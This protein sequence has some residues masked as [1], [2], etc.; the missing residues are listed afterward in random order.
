MDHR[1]LLDRPVTRSEVFASLRVMESEIA[2]VRAR[3]V[4]ELRRLMRGWGAEPSPSELAAEMDVSVNTAKRLLEAAWRTP[5]RSEAMSKFSSGGWSFDRAAAMAALVGVGADDDTLAEAEGRDIAGVERLRGLQK[6][7]TK[8][9]EHEAHAQRRL[10]TWAS[11]DESV[12]FVHAELT[13][14]DW[15]TVTTALDKRADLFPSK[16][17]TADQRRADALVAI[18]QDWLDGVASGPGRSSG[19]VV[20]VVVAADT[21]AQTNAEAG[22]SVTA[23]PRVGPE[24]LERIMCEGSVE[25]VVEPGTGVPLAVGP[26]SRVIPPKVRRAVLARDGG[27]VIAGCTSSYRLQVHHVTPRSRGGTHDMEN[28]VTLCWYHHHVSI[29]GQGWSIDPDSPARNRRLIPP[30]SGSPPN[31]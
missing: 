12:G 23:G 3:Q 5:E 22:V 8:R 26:T 9:S 24:T 2:G 17:T 21:A 4:R 1:L 16:D 30:P 19:P 27:C 20:T 11:L 18:A 31:T 6:R 10:R 28:L 29:H 25:V 15:A 7:I 13:G 14:Y